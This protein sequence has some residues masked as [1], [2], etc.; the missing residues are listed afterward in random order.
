MSRPTASRAA[1]ASAPG[2][3]TVSTL[4][5]HCRNCACSSGAT[6]SSSQITVIGKGSAS[7]VIASA[8]EPASSIASTRPVVIASTRGRSWSMRRCVNSRDASFRSRVWS[9]GSRLTSEREP[10]WTGIRRGASGAVIASLL[11]RKSVSTART[12]ACR[13]TSQPSWPP[14][15]CTRVT[16]SRVRSF[17]YSSSASPGVRTR[18][19]NTGSGGAVTSVM[20][21]LTIRSACGRERRSRLD[22]RPAASPPT[23]RRPRPRPERRKRPAPSESGPVRD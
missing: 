3:P 2:P 21:L 4:S 13:V 6:P 22:C 14:G 18:N 15:S 12:S 20:V 1:S 23:R 19:G 17:A 16:A 11:N 5:P 7:A 9:G 8:S 10:R